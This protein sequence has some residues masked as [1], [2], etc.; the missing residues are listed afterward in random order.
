MLKAS[1]IFAFYERIYK[2]IPR[3]MY[4]KILYC[5]E[6][7]YLF[8]DTAFEKDTYTCRGGMILN[9]MHPVGIYYNVEW[10]TDNFGCSINGEEFQEM[11]NSMDSKF[12]LKHLVNV[13]YDIPI[14]DTT[15]PVLKNIGYINMSIRD[16]HWCNNYYLFSDFI[17]TSSI[18][19]M[20]FYRFHIKDATGDMK[21]L[22]DEIND[23][24]PEGQYYLYKALVPEGKSARK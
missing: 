10:D 3:N 23:T 9:G 7:C 8:V 21:K 5:T 16:S 2:E 12:I 24:S 1:K 14:E 18:G 19:Q 6:D 4:Y 13:S 17:L 20:P 22:I 11:Y 15:Y